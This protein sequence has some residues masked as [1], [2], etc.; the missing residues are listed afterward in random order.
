M[1]FRDQL[2]I[3]EIAKRTSLF[4]NTVKKWLRK[5]NG[6]DPQYKRRPRPTK[7]TPFE[8]QLKQALIASITNSSN[9]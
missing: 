6:T 1:H 5:P 2:S 4:R 3:N 7:L 8:D 9:L